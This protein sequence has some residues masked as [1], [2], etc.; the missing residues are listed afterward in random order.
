MKQR[1]KS[2]MSGIERDMRRGAHGVREPL[3]PKELREYA[4]Y[5]ES[6]AGY[7]D[8]R[9]AVFI[10]RMHSE[11]EALRR[12]NKKLVKLIDEALDTAP[13]PISPDSYNKILDYLYQPG[14]AE[15]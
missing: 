10:L 14:E 12:I 8:H 9:C 1:K 2:R 4:A 3:T 15:K 5:G 11:V 6:M 13:G 7:P